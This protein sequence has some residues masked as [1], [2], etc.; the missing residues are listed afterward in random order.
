MGKSH[1]KY[2]AGNL[3]IAMW[4]ALHSNS[5]KPTPQADHRSQPS[6]ETRQRSEGAG[7]DG[8]KIVS[9]PFEKFTVDIERVGYTGSNFKV[10]VHFQSNGTREGVQP[11][12]VFIEEAIR[13]KLQREGRQ[14]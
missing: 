12:R 2:L 3:R 11:V 6:R 14:P 13:E 8:G 4:I 7:G 5:V 10:Y 1:A 9:A